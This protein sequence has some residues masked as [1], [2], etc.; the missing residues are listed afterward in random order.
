[1]KIELFSIKD[2]L[3]GFSQPFACANEAVALRQFIGSVRAQQP[4]I[5]NTFP[6]N[7]ELWKIGE[8]DDQTGE[9]TSNIKFIARATTYVMPDIT[10]DSDEKKE[11]K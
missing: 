6:E 1:M 9:L 2:V 10:P 5:C 4:N 8:L 3:V 7:K 11:E